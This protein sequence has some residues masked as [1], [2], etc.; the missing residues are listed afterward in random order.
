MKLSEFALNDLNTDGIYICCLIYF[1]NIACSSDYMQLAV[2][3]V[4]LL[5]GGPS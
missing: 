4:L 1:V 5:G 2:E 3:Q